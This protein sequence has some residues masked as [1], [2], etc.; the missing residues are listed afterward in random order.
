M[1]DLDKSADG[2][3]K[4]TTVASSI[5]AAMELTFV[6]SSSSKFCCFTIPCFFESHSRSLFKQRCW[7]SR[8]L[9]SSSDFFSCSVGAA[10]R[11]VSV[12][13]DCAKE[14]TSVFKVSISSFPSVPA[15]VTIS[16]VN[17]SVNQLQLTTVNQTTT[18]MNH[19][20]AE[21]SHITHL[22]PNSY[23]DRE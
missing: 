17:Q 21:M 8:I 7:Y 20:T 11:A 3:S 18:T 6:C 23:L 22:F 14:V 4:M 9:V 2:S 13:T 1:T 16:Q 15:I 19:L 12:C 5:L 10:W